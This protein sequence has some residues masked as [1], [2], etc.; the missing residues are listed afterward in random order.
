MMLLIFLIA[1]LGTAQKPPDAIGAKR[2]AEVVRTITEKQRE[3]PFWFVLHS[4]FLESIPFA[5]R[6]STS[7][8][9][10]GGDG[11]ALL[12]MS[13]CVPPNESDATSPTG[14]ATTTESKTVWCVAYVKGRNYGGSCTPALPNLKNVER[15]KPGQK[16]GRAERFWSEF[17]KAFDFETTERQS[18]EGRPTIVL[19]F[20]P[21]PGYLPPRNDDTAI[22]PFIRGRIWIDETELEIARIQYEF[23]K[24]SSALVFGQILKGT[25]YSM[26][27]QKQLDGYWLPTHAE[28]ELHLD[29]LNVTSHE[30]SS[31]QFSDYIK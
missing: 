21:K 29:V 30:T 7:W 28:T 23:F 6:V 1:S 10:S 9:G 12:V 31:M 5:Y 26:D 18:R 3:R 14:P 15:P 16:F 19:S 20:V 24:D 2:T 27:L 25:R 8:T 22:F 11:C 4:V 17:R 13:L